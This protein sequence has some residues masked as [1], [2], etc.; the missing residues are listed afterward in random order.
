MNFGT[1]D[2]RIKRLAKVHIRTLYDCKPRLAKLCSVQ[3]AGIFYFHINLL[4]KTPPTRAL[5]SGVDFL[6]G[7]PEIFSQQTIKFSIEN[8]PRHIENLC[9]SA[10]ETHSPTGALSVFC[11]KKDGVLPVETF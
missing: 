1:F 7:S 6:S 4:D 10:R 3:S 5:P 9:N 8:F 2:E 11:S